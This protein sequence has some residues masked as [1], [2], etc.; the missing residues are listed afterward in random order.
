MGNFDIKRTLITLLVISGIWLIWINFFA[1]KQQLQPQQQQQQQTQ[2][3]TPT[4]TQTPTGA[5]TPPPAPEKPSSA[6]ASATEHKEPAEKVEIGTARWKARFTTWGGAV[7]SFQLLDKQYHKVVDGHEQPLDLVAPQINRPTFVTAFPES[8]F[9]LAE[10]AA[11]TIEKKSADE[12]VFAWQGEGVKITK[13]FHA[14]ST[15]HTLSMTI[16]V[17]ATGDK[18]VSAH[19]NLTQFGWQDFTQKSGFGRPAPNIE[20]GACYI[21]A[22]TQKKAFEQLKEKGP[23]EESGDLKWAGV[24]DRYFLLAAAPAPDAQKGAR[25]CHL[26]VADVSA[27]TYRV[28]S[29]FPE[30]KVDAGKSASLD[31]AVF[32]GPKILKELDA[33]VVAGQDTKLGEAVDYG[34]WS[35]ISRV[36]LAI[37]VGVHKVVSSWGVAIIALTLLIKLL[38]YP[39]TQKSMRS[40]KEMAK[41]K[42]EIEKLQKRYKDDKQRLNMEMMNLYKTH[43]VNP[44]GGCLPMLIQL[45]VWWALYATLGNAVELY[46]SR[47]LWMHDLTQ[48]DPFYI[49]PIAMGAF[50]FLQQRITPMPTDSQQQKTMMYMMPVLF[51]FMS[52]WFPAG[53]TVYIL[54]NTLLTMLQQWF[55]N[56]KDPLKKKVLKPARAS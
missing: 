8:S 27:S 28:T 41:L 37:L 22:K 5:P 42:P 40:G 30:M 24:T 25:A 32:G 47:F 39:L 19:I 54:T 13:R 33:V 35:P 15:P 46:R 12:V 52:L 10:D 1:K 50:M 53:L 2:T 26:D 56:R 11:W 6:S 31:F 36:M 7:E 44:L 9:A 20:M 4:P 14:D 3:P 34:W 55:I 16:T 43:G 17:A 38:T 21:N 23:F 29:R 49:T 18:P 45:P 51:T 48:P